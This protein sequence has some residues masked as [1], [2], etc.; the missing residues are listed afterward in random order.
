MNEEGVVSQIIHGIALHTGRMAAVL[1]AGAVLFCAAPESVYASAA[2]TESAA[3][4]Q[5][6]STAQDSSAA[7]TD[8]SGTPAPEAPPEV[9]TNA[10]A[11]WP[12]GED[13]KSLTACLIDAD[14]GAVLY[15]KSIGAKMAPASITKV[16]TLLLALENGNLE[17]RVAMTE[18][19][20]RYAETGSMN[21]YTKVGEEF[22]VEELIYG[23]FLYSA[24]DMATQLGEYIGGGSIDNFVQMMNDRAAEIGC[25]GTHFA[26]ACGMPDPEHVTTAHDMALI[27]REGLRREDFRIIINTPT[28]TIPPTNMTAGERELTSH[29]PLLVSPSYYY[30]G[31]IGGKTGYTDGARHTLINAVSRDGMTLIVVTMHAEDAGY[32]A[33]DNIHILDYGFNNFA[34]QSVGNP[35]LTAGGG[36]VTL[37]KGA[38]VDACTIE[39]QDAG[40]SDAGEMVNWIYS[41]NGQRVGNLLMTKENAAK[42]KKELEGA[43]K[44]ESAA[45]KDTASSGKTEKTGEKDADTVKENSGQNGELDGETFR[46]AIYVLGGVVAAG[47]LAII[48]TLAVRRRKLKKKIQAADEAYINEQ[49]D[50]PA[51]LPVDAEALAVAEK[52]EKEE[53]SENAGADTADGGEDSLQSDGESGNPADGS[54]GGAETEAEAS[55]V[56]SNEGTDTPAVD[57]NASDVIGEFSFGAPAQSGEENSG[58]NGTGN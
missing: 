2:P 11:G 47:I 20:V 28:Y 24:N 45:S 42:Y 1:L 48:I 7:Q 53:K 9:S 37:P 41:Y 49:K 15:D 46:L 33:E 58:M 54:A 57:E 18:T 8:A 30:P 12:Q 35:D 56:S 44:T 10:I 22:T 21:L 25:T 26:N 16:M 38:S 50:S 39:E 17:D 3:P 29:N 51:G 34:V 14:T 36:K 31:T 13:C 27:M 43:K 32:A 5:G 55:P 40:S 19:G 52:A 6:S 4:A 23:T